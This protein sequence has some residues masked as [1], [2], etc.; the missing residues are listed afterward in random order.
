MLIKIT[1]THHR[2]LDPRTTKTFYIGDTHDFEEELA[3]DFIRN[4]FAVESK[5]LKTKIEN[6]AILEVP[7]TKSEEVIGE[8]SKEEAEKSAKK[9]KQQSK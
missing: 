8:E 1:K 6:K 3:Q 2:A 4:G 5:Q 9:K 7:E